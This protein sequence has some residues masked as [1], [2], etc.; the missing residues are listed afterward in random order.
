[1]VKNVDDC[2]P[3]PISSNVLFCGDQQSTNSLLD[4]MFNLLCLT[5]MASGCHLVF[6]LCLISTLFTAGTA[7]DNP[8][9]QVSGC[10]PGWTQFG[11]R[12][13]IFFRIARAWT[14]AERTCISAGGNLASIHSADENSFLRNLVIRVTGHCLH[15]WIGGFDAVK[16][17]TWMWTDGSRFDYR[18]WGTGEPNNVG[19]E[20]CIEMNFRGSF[21]NDGRCSWTRPFVCAK[22]L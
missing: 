22:D 19:V 13:F 16:E 7:I 17:G 9:Q 14:D 2:F 4:L 12:C 8:D 15:T 5:Q 1:M 3:Q 11:S 21:W 10:P 18:R 20:N 6:F